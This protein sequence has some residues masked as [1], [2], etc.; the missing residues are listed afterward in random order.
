MRKTAEYETSG[1]LYLPCHELPA[2]APGPSRRVTSDNA[3]GCKAE[4]LRSGEEQYL[5]SG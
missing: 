2:P 5:T 1:R 3:T 4:G